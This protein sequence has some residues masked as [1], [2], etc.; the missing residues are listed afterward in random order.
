[1]CQAARRPA[2]FTRRF[3]T[4]PGANSSVEGN[5]FSLEPALRVET[6]GT[7]QGSIQSSV[8]TLESS[9]QRVHY[10]VN[11]TEDPSSTGLEDVEQNPYW[12]CF[13]DMRLFCPRLAVFSSLGSQIARL[14]PLSNLGTWLMPGHVSTTRQ[15]NHQPQQLGPQP[16]ATASVFVSVR[17]WTLNRSSSA[18]LERT[19]IPSDHGS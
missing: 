9:K 2:R 6:S 14:S 18:W 3:A 15:A 5:S 16:T 12:H 7:G 17:Y 19:T 11:D 13:V 4:Q 8:D 10:G 1:M